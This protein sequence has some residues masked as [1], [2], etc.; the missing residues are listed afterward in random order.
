M[1]K[2]S[3]SREKHT[4]RQALTEILLVR[5]PVGVFEIITRWSI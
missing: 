3:F 1:A 2:L 4:C 5:F